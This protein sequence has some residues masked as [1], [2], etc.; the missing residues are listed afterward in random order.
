M[1]S[2]GALDRRE[3]TVPDSIQALLREQEIIQYDNLFGGRYSHRHTFCGLIGGA[4]K[5]GRSGD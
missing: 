3:K 2:D 1:P 4:C 5:T